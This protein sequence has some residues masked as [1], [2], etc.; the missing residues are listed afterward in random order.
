MN[1]KRFLGTLNVTSCTKDFGLDTIRD[2]RH[3]A[4]KTVFN[5]SRERSEKEQ[6]ANARA[7]VVRRVRTW[8]EMISVG[9]ELPK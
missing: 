5:L 1:N 4:N 6:I 3:S 2:D 9:A 8:K 7:A